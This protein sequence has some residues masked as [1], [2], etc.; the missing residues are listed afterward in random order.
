MKKETIKTI[1]DLKGF[2]RT[3]FKDKDV[4]VFLFGSRARNQSSTFSDI[5]IGFISRGDIKKDLTILRETIEESHLPYKV[6]LVDL[7]KDKKLLEIVK[8]EGKRW[9]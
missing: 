4:E 8:K 7:S 9:L 1:D 6:D 3:F 5:D 2:I